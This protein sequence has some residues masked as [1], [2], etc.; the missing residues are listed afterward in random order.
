MLNEL[1]RGLWVM[2]GWLAVNTATAAGS[3]HF[4]AGMPS[5]SELPGD[6]FAPALITLEADRFGASLVRTL[7]PI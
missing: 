4:I 7:T 3:Y 6:N 5:N 2:L 1:S